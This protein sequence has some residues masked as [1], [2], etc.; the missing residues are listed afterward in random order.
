MNTI[1]KYFLIF[2]F[3]CGTYLI[4]AKG[5]SEAFNKANILFDSGK[6]FEAS[7]EYER[8]LYEGKPKE[9]FNYSRYKKALCYRHLHRFNDALNELNR[10]NLFS[11]SD[12]LRTL[13]FYEKAFNHLLADNAQQA[14]FNIQRINE[15]QVTAS[16]HN[17]IEPLKILILNKNRE[18]FKARNVFQRWLLDMDIPQE[19]K[20][21]YSNS[22]NSLYSE[23][24]IPKNYSE[25]KAQNLSRF[26]PGAGQVYTNHFWEGAA[27][28]TLN[29]A[30][31]GFGLHQLWFR[32][33]FT[34][35]IGLGVF[36]KTYFG[37]MERAV[38]LANIERKNEMT[39]FNQATSQLISKILSI[40]EKD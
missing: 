1:I 6:Y 19:V 30:A 24:N 23:K 31:L 26:I 35:Y 27:S 11:A 32:Y 38:N 7:I 39:Q 10:I 34:G 14:L 18:W 37:G 16:T 21:T 28:F 36:Y 13:I 33:Y 22:I 20:K 17:N 8:V 12:S 3:L 15:K 29:A 40:P 9:F 25:E 2:T 4:E 5:Q